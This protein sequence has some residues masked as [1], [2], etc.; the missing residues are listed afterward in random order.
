M[1]P[2]I[3]FCSTMTTFVYRPRGSAEAVGEHRLLET[4]SMLKRL[5]R[6]LTRAAP[7]MERLDRYSLN[8]GGKILVLSFNSLPITIIVALVVIAWLSFLTVII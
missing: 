8:R 3:G 1:A 2:P 4:S 7:A 5:G 6:A